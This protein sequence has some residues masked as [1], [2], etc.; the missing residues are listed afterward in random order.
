MMLGMKETGMDVCREFEATDDGKTAEFVYYR[1]M[2]HYGVAI[3]AQ[4]IAKIHSKKL[5]MMIGGYL[6]QQGLINDLSRK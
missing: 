5:G 2:M 6:R 1:Q 4:A 3:T